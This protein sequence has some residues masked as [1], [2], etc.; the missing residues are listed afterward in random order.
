MRDF[1]ESESTHT[2]S[3]Y[4]QIPD[5]TSKTIVLNLILFKKG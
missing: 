3:N 4:Q 1:N 2:Y 5:K